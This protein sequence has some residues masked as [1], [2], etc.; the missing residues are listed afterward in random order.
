MD[1]EGNT[2]ASTPAHTVEA[3]TPQRH[4]QRRWVQPGN[5]AFA[6]RQALVPVVGLEAGHAALCLPLAFVPFG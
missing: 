1:T 4:G 3:V 2:A 6:A 5:F